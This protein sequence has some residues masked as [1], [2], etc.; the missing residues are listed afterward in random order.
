M[1]EPEI[2]F[3]SE[4]SESPLEIR[5]NFGI[6]AG[7]QATPAEIDDLG[8]ML[9]PLLDQVTIVSEERHEITGDSEVSVSTVRVELGAASREQTGTLL[10]RCEQ[11]A[12]SCIAGRRPALSEL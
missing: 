12:A 10:A 8:R 1:T 9:L 11:W 5:I 7:R 3:L 4:P 6:F 2:A